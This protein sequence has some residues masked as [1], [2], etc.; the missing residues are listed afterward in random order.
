MHCKHSRAQSSVNYLFWG[1][2]SSPKFANGIGLH[3]LGIL[4][5]TPLTY[6]TFAGVGCSQVSNSRMRA[7]GTRNG[8]YIYFASF[9]GMSGVRIPVACLPKLK[10]VG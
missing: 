3:H 6:W 5:T 8:N 1:I 9:G 10:Y 7:D 4:M 2:T